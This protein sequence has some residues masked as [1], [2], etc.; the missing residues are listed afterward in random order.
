MTSDEERQKGK[1]P[2]SS[3][4][5]DEVK[6]GFT[7]LTSGS[8]LESLGYIKLLFLEEYSLKCF[9]KISVSGFTSTVNLQS[10]AS[11]R[12][13]ESKQVFLRPSSGQDLL[14]MS[15]WRSFI[16]ENWLVKFKSL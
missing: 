16:I 3:W 14:F 5:K 12:Q 1:G 2:E 15:F 9:F 8:C 10:H 4:S 6:P 13:R 7:R 11:W